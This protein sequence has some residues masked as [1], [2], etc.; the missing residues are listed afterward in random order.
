MNILA[1]D[2]STEQFSI[3]ILKNNKIV[4]NLTKTLNK[5]YSKFLVPILEESLKQSKLD[6][7]KINNILISLGPGSFTG[8]RLGISAA[9]GLGMP[10]KIN[11][12]GFNN[13]D[14]LIKSVDS[15]IKG[16][17]LVAIIKSKKNNYYFQLF[18]S[19]KRPIKKISFFSIN[20]LP[21]FFFNKNIVFCGDLDTNLI[22]LIKKKNKGIFVSKKKF[23]NTQILINEIMKK[24]KKIKMT[25]YLNPIYVYP[26][27][28]K[29][30]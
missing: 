26:H 25:R 4:L 17:K 8:V 14:I 22:D 7:K 15:N 9:K 16:K 12:L 10:H 18:D 30:N 19:K 24:K 11:I 21:N 1:F 29:K 27:Y 6:I 3:S 2:T 5:T 28:A 20:K 23:S 13:M